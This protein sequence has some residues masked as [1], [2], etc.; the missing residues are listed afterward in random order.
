MTIPS[1]AQAPGISATLGSEMLIDVK[2]GKP[3]PYFIQLLTDII[4]RNNA[5]G[6][7]IPC[8][9]TGTDIITLAVLQPSPV[10]QGYRFGDCF[11]FVA[12]NSSSGVVTAKVQLNNGTSLSTI[13]VYK[14]SGATQAT[15][16][17]IVAGSFYTAWYV[18]TLDVAAGGFVIKEA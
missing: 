3:L 7:I 5:G 9:A 17:D 16:G 15:A 14:A 8:E 1:A 10:I 13:K 18:P 12:Q 6:R 4:E 11:P 2:T